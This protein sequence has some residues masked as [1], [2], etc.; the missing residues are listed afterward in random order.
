D[1]R[2]LVR[3]NRLLLE[4]AAPDLIVQSARQL[5]TKVA[6]P[7][8][9]DRL[10]PLGWFYIAFVVFT[11]VAITNAVNLTDGLDGLAAGASVV[12]LSAFTALAYIVSRADWSSYL[13]ITYIPEASELA[14]FGAALL[15][16][17]LGFLWFNA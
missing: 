7:G 6:I 16:T 3:F 2:Q 13:F 1:K 8:L 17:G 15:G 4:A 11:M 9:K 10:I 12:A 14:V 5:Q